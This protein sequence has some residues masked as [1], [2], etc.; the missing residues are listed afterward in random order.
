MGTYEIR[1]DPPVMP[2]VSFLYGRNGEIVGEVSPI[3][4]PVVKAFIDGDIT[5]EEYR[6]L[7]V[8]EALANQNLRDFMYSDQPP[9]FMPEVQRASGWCGWLRRILK[10]E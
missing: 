3:V 10:V 4:G 9:D 5:A 8:K 6:A 2:S 7:H 1:P